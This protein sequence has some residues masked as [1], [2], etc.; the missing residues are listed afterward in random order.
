VHRDPDRAAQV[1][2]EAADLGLFDS[3]RLVTEAIPEEYGG[4]AAL[5]GELE[6][7]GK[8]ACVWLVLDASFPLSLPKIFVRPWDALGVLPHIDAR[9]FVCHTQ[10][11]GLVLNWRQPL[12]VIEEGLRRAQ[13]VLT[14][15]LTGANLSDFALEFEAYWDLLPNRVAACSL[16]EPSSVAKPIVV[17]SEQHAGQQILYLADSTA[18]VTSYRNALAEE[19]TQSPQRGLYLPL[20]GR[21]GLCPPRH[22]RPFWTPEEARRHLAPRFSE[23][24][25][26]VL[27][28]LGKHARRQVEYVVIGVPRPGGGETLI[29]LC[30]EYVRKKHPLLKGGKAHRVI[31]MKLVRRDHSYLVR[32]GGGE[33]N[34]DTKRV[35][36]A[37]CGAVGAHVAV[38]L[39]QAGIPEIT[40]VDHDTLNPENTFRHVLGRRYWGKAK[41]EALAHKI[42]DDLPYVRVT[43]IQQRIQQAM[44]EGTVTVADF[45]LVIMATGDPTVELWVNEQVRASGAGAPGVLFMWVEPLGIGGHALLTHEPGGRGCFECL[46][47]SPV[48]DI[49]GDLDNRA[50]FAAPGQSFGRALS[51]CATLHTPFAASDAVDT[52]IVAT[53]LAL[54]YL[55]GTERQNTLRSWRGNAA[56]FLAEGFH[57]SARYGLTE[58]ALTGQAYAFATP[59]C[60]V[61]GVSEG[62]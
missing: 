55:T 20:T 9:G 18:Q 34:I 58:E 45:D 26:Q 37:G 2:R 43:P 59:R 27:R 54:A 17:T 22:D 12:L 15:G 28:Q 3:P 42:M 53:R 48:D 60:P 21:D 5:E 13:A 41:V 14:A 40:L 38:Q 29:G 56:V 50:A 39:A 57:L 30:F 61:C 24:A 4:I 31:P 52:A 23:Q 35:L 51:G 10:T 7:E 33:A 25:E 32:R 11:E 8:R 46:Y 47:T 49:D 1:L 44:V 36:I 16:V 6:I 62:E 19:T